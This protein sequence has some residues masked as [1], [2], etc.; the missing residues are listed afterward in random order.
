MVY[1]MKK[2]KIKNLLTNEKTV[3]VKVRNFFTISKIGL[4]MQVI[5]M[6]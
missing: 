6:F 3:V 1:I 4:S 2:E 5:F